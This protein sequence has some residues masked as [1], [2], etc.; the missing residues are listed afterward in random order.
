MR[1]RSALAASALAGALLL[2]G[3]QGSTATG[4]ENVESGVETDEDGAQPAPNTGRQ[5]DPTL[6]EEPD[7]GSTEGGQGDTDFQGDDS[8]AP[9]G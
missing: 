7:A 6:N 2:G 3:C 1:T 8:D 9:G 5:D 4:S